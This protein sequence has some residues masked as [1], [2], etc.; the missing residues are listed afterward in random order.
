MNPSEERRF[1]ALIEIEKVD[2]IH[3]D[4]SNIAFRLKERVKNALDKEDRDGIG[5]DIM[6]ALTMVAFAY[7]A[8]INFIGFSVLKPWREWSP[9]HIK[10][11][12]VFQKLGIELVTGERPYSSIVSLRQVRNTLAHGK[13]INETAT[14]ESIGTN[15]ELE[16]EARAASIPAWEELIT[17]DFLFQAYDDVN[18]IWHHMLNAADINVIETFSGGGRSISF[19]G[20]AD[21][22]A[23]KA[24]SCKETQASLGL[25][26][27]PP[28]QV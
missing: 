12:R 21:Q 13:P 18:A 9:S 1:K 8:Y 27:T 14:W 10:E 22:E 4:L 6:A 7:E 23:L 17:P 2:R 16:A 3:N 11:A 28:V 5:L 24:E 20:Y 25:L 26:V 19:L 15:S